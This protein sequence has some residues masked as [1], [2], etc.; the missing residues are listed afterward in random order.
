MLAYGFSM[1]LRCVIVED[2][3]MFLQML[4]SMLRSVPDLHVVATART[5]AEG[6][7]ACEEHRPDLLVLDLSLPDG[8]GVDVARRLARLNRSARTIVLS[9]EA[10]TFVCPADLNRQIH[11]VLNKTQAFDDLASEL[12]GLLPKARGGSQSLKTG[13][14]RASLTAREYEIFQMIGRGLMSKEIAEKLSVSPHTIQ[15]H[16]KKIAHKLG[17]SGPEL[18]QQ[19]LRHYHTTLGAP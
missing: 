17:T 18:A 11:A 8:A 12:K 13:D 16:R 19:A 6:L 15:T 14:V 10:S 4:H 5:V 3:T 1:G 7:A 2:Q 9:G